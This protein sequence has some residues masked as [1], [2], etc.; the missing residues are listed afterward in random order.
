LKDQPLL[1]DDVTQ[2]FLSVLDW[3]DASSLSQV[4]FELAQVMLVVNVRKQ[5]GA[6]CTADF[7]GIGCVVAQTRE[8][9]VSA[10]NDRSP[11]LPS[12][13]VYQDFVSSFFATLDDEMMHKLD[14]LHSRLMFRCFQI[15][16]IHI[17]IRNASIHQQ[18]RVVAV[19]DLWDDTFSTVRMLPRFLQVENSHDVFVFHLLDHIEFFY[20]FVI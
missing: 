7:D 18:L 12:M 11:S 14:N 17:E 15:L 4:L 1:F 3:I 9:N 5:L 10:N 8:E 2:G 6:T 20:G 13:T 16:P 19:A